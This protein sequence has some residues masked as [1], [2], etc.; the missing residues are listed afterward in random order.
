MGRVWNADGKLGMNYGIKNAIYWKHK[1]QAN[2]WQGEAG[3]EMDIWGKS[4]PDREKAGVKALRWEC[5]WVSMKQQGNQ[6][7]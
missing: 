4:T 1:V 7:G 6:C 2:T 5:A 3:N